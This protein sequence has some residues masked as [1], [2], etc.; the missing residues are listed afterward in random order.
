LID[1]NDKNRK[2][3]RQQAEEFAS[4]HDL[5]YFETSGLT[6]FN[7]NEAFQKLITGM[8]LIKKIRN[9]RT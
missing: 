7:I 8:D 6:D 1:K 9:I 3:T 2:V 5:T 4:K